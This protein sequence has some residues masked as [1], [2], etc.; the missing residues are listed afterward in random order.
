MKSME[1]GSRQQRDGV[2][3]THLRSSDGACAIVADHGAHLLSWCPANGAEALFMSRSSAYGGIAAIR[4]GVPVIF[5]QFGARGDGRRHG[6]AR[7]VSW[8]YVGA[9]I[10]D[11]AAVASWVLAA[12]DMAAGDGADDATEAGALPGFHLTCDLRLAGDTID[13]GLTIANTSQQTWRC[14]AALHTYLRVDALEAVRISGLEAAP[15]IDQTLPTKAG[16]AL[17]AASM[18]RDATAL[19]FTGEV[20]RI[21]PQAPP[22]VLLQDAQRRLEVRMQGFP[23]LVAWNPGRTKAV[24]LA[25]LH[26]DGYRQFVCIEAAAIIVPIELA[27]GAH[28]RGVQSLRQLA[29]Q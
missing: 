28:W 8:Q 17:A 20:D 3:V 13:I 12:P 11:N 10:E 23:D 15:Y 9:A 21:Y 29:N 25:D 24:A 26:A 16:V 2:M 1:N 5:P 27:S 6:F 18:H 7:N 22:L 4:G 14:L 19:V